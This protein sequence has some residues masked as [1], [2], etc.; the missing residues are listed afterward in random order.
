MNSRFP[1]FP[2]S[3]PGKGNQ[4]S[5]ERLRT[6]SPYFDTTD[7]PL[8]KL[9]KKFDRVTSQ[10]LSPSF[11]KS[12][13]DNRKQN[14]SVEPE[15]V[16]STRRPFS[17]NE[18][19]SIKNVSQSSLLDQYLRDLS[20]NESSTNQSK[21]QS[22]NNQSFK[23]TSRYED[24]PLRDLALVNELTAESS[25]YV[26]N[27]NETEK[28]P[29]ETENTSLQSQT[30]VQEQENSF[31]KVDIEEM[32]AKE[33][34]RDE[35][36]CMVETDKKLT[37]E[38]SNSG[39]IGKLENLVDTIDNNNIF[40]NK[41][42]NVNDMISFDS[43]NF[44][45]EL[46]EEEQIINNE[47]IEYE[48]EVT[49][50]ISAINSQEDPEVKQTHISDI[51]EQLSN[52]PLK[53]NET[54]TVSPP[55]SVF[56]QTSEE[57]EIASFQNEE[58]EQ[59]VTISISNED[60]LKSTRNIEIESYPNTKDLIEEPTIIENVIEPEVEITSIP[61]LC[62]NSPR[63]TPSPSNEQNNLVYDLPED[64]VKSPTLIEENTFTF[65]SNNDETMEVSND[66]PD[67]NKIDE[68][69]IRE[70]DSIP[71]IKTTSISEEITSWGVND[72]Q[73]NENTEI[74]N[75][76]IEKNEIQPHTFTCDSQL[77][78]ISNNNE[79]STTNILESSSK[80]MSPA[81]QN[82]DVPLSDSPKWNIKKHH[83]NS[84]PKQCS[85]VQK[86]LP[87]SNPSPV[88]DFDFDEEFTKSDIISPTISEPET[89]HISKRLNNF[90]SRE[91]EPYNFDEHYENSIHSKRNSPSPTIT[92]FPSPTISPL[93]CTSPTVSPHSRSAC[94][95]SPY[96]RTPSPDND[97]S[98][99]GHCFAG[100]WNDSDI[101]TRSK[102]EIITST[103]DL[104]RS[105]QERDM[106][107]S[108]D[109]KHLVKQNPPLPS[110]SIFTKKVC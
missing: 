109:L 100:S 31:T 18:I 37:V 71:L 7:N 88:S 59:S 107:L 2:H 15:K 38:Y 70:P 92:P 16:I 33:I 42:E 66:V 102:R 30:I 10:D 39:E 43:E 77:S 65:N 19:I 36:N 6:T 23:S 90:S 101:S 82:T 83:T 1:F 3:I 56:P 40:N 51:E 24:I 63:N 64:D 45:K 29:N 68:K 8:A 106:T 47:V 62:D 104:K 50:N 99:N 61:P 75:E 91:Q 110:S 17:A 48:T 67:E 32:E 5:N 58:Q 55:N 87:I 74:Q 76:N 14:G 11:N 108:N 85:P 49:Q 46:I 53:P 60:Q 26:D 97:N 34:S 13:E 20:P 69:T 54:D 81:S 103:S 27:S 78:T 94:S 105:V 96:L 93:S 89:N 80:P 73:S 52:S 95:V 28:P 44:G 9:W 86:E 57:G 22:R 98:S 21:V 35:P 79:V 12:N 72:E 84:S 25:P 41:Q 4:M